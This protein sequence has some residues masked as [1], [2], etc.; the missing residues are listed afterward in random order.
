MYFTHRN[1]PVFRAKTDLSDLE[2]KQ[3]IN[4]ISTCSSLHVYWIEKWETFGSFL[5][6]KLSA[7]SLTYTDDAKVLF[8]NA[9]S[10]SVRNFIANY[11]EECLCA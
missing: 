2:C 7:F 9:E 1:G 5:K 11:K 6:A 3:L 10:P 8:T 4:L